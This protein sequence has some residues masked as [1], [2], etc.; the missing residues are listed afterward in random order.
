LVLSTK[1]LVAAA[2]FLVAATKISFVVRNFVAVTKPF[3]RDYRPEKVAF[4]SSCDLPWFSR[5]SMEQY[6]REAQH[7]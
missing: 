1:R 6:W 4:S 3:F 5:S 2:K 7:T